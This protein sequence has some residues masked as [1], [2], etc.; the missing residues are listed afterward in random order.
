MNQ[1]IQENKEECKH[2]LHGNKDFICPKCDH[3]C[4]GVGVVERN[5]EKHC[6]YYGCGFDFR[7]KPKENCPHG[8]EEDECPVVNCANFPQN[9]SREEIP[10][11]EQRFDEKWDGCFSDQNGDYVNPQVKD[12]IRAEIEAAKKR[13][14]EATLARVRQALKEQ[15]EP[16][17][18]AKWH[19][20][21]SIDTIE[22]V[23]SAIEHKS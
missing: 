21:V 3:R 16:Y 8:A 13:T 6:S 7:R 23:L 20:N 22:K 12:F 9:T 14:V 15:A 19:N 10:E 1:P 5:D 18:G 2:Y 11:W 4:P 17:D